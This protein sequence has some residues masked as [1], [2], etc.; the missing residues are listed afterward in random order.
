MA[1]EPVK[2]VVTISG[3]CCTGVYGGRFVEVVVVDFDNETG[4]QVW[5]PTVEPMP[6]M[7][8]DVVRALQSEVPSFVEK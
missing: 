6:Q 5:L 1:Q 4:G 3:G 7:D 2:V 8:I